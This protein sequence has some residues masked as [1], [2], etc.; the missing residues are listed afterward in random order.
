[1][2]KDEKLAKVAA[3]WKRQGS[4]MPSEVGGD[5]SDSTMANCVLPLCL[6]LYAVYM[7]KTPFANIL[8]GLF[9]HYDKKRPLAFCLVKI[10]GIY[11]FE[12][13]LPGKIAR[14]IRKSREDIVRCCRDLN[15]HMRECGG[16]YIC[17]NQFT[18]ADIGIIATLERL[19]AADGLESIFVKADV[20][21]L[22]KYWDEVR[23]RES[24][25]RAIADE[26]LSIVGEGLQQIQE[27]KLRYPKFKE[28]F[29]LV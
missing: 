2:P 8:Y 13:L 11:F 6:P 1:M 10:F 25:K 5:G 7:R 21:H 17:G 19:H 9:F 22:Q 14:T 16:P 29:E 4:L 27:W 18:Q 23:Q 28:M 15:A 26:E 24:Y 12:Y 20:P 3:K